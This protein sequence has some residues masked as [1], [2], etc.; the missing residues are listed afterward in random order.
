[1]IARLPGRRIRATPID[2]PS[3]AYGCVIGF[4]LAYLGLVLVEAATR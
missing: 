3:I 4:P 1:M 2:W